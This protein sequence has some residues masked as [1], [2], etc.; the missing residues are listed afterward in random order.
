[1]AGGPVFIAPPCMYNPIESLLRS[2]NAGDSYVRVLQGEAV[3]L[4][5]RLLPRKAPIT[6]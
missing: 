1:M 4:A 5:D 3:T 6:T 2:T